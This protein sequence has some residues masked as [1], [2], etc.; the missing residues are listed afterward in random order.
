MN[1]A[2]NEFGRIQHTEILKINTGER[3]QCRSIGKAQRGHGAAKIDWE[4]KPLEIDSHADTHCFGSNF[5]PIYFTQHE[6][7][8][9]P[10]LPEYSEQVNIQI[11][12]GATAYTAENG[13]V[14]VLI[15]GQGLWFGDKMERSLINPYQCRAYGVDL[16]DDPVDPNGREMGIDCE[17]TFIPLSMVGSTCGTI[18][19]CP[20]DEELENCTKVYLSDEEDWDPSKENIFPDKSNKRLNAALAGRS[21]CDITLNGR[22]TKTVIRDD[23]FVNEFDRAMIDTN[24]SLSQGAMAERLINNVNVTINSRGAASTITRERHHGKDPELIA[25]K[26]G[27]GLEKAKQTLKATTQ[28]AVRS[29]V[30]P[31]TRRYRTDLMSQ[32]LRRLNCRFYTDTLFSKHK[33]IEGNTCGQLF[34]DGEGFVILYPMDSKAKAGQKLTELS[35]DVGI[36]NELYMDNAPE[37]VGK[38]SEMMKE[39]RRMKI[40]HH[41][42]EPYSPW[43]NAA[44]NIIGIIKSKHHQRMIRR[45]VPFD[46]WDYG[47]VWEAQIYSRTANKDGKVGL[48]RLTGDSIDISDWIDFEFYDIVWY[49][50]SQSADEKPKIGRWLGVSHNVGS[51]LCYFV[52]TEK[53]NVIS[54]T[55]VQHFTS[56]DVSKP[57]TQQAMRDY[58][59]N[60]HMHIK[61]RGHVYT[62]ETIFYGDDEENNTNQI[63]QEESYYPLPETPELDDVLNFETPEAAADS[64][65]QYIGVEVQMGPDDGKGNKLMAKVTKRLRDN[66][67]KTVTT[68]RAQ[69]PLH[70]SSIYEVEY[71][72]GTTEQL[73][74]NIIAENMMSQIDSEGNQFLLLNEIQDHRKDGR[75]VSRANGFI[76]SSGGNR[77]PKKTTAGWQLL[78]EWKDGSMDWVALKDLKEANPLELAEYAVAN[79]ID[80][81]PAFNWWVRDAIKRRDRIISKVKAK[82]WRTTHKFGIRIPKTVEE[83]YQIDRET[84]TDY[85]TKAIAKEMKNVRI[86]FERIPNVSPEQMKSGK[87]KPGHKFC[88]THM[89]FDIKMDGQFTRKAR[90]VADGHKT[91]APSSITYSSVV[92]RDSVRLAFTIAALNDLEVMACDIG[93]AYLNAPCRE[94]LWTTAGPE[95]GS[96]AGSVMTI[97]RALYG[98]KSSGAAWRAKFA[99][100]LRSMG[101]K[102]TEADP[103]VWMKKDFKETGEPYYKYIL[104]LAVFFRKSPLLAGSI[105]SS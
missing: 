72:D 48:E 99:D 76:L 103:D 79:N 101:Y 64:Y 98:L 7:T 81:E 18:T 65:D 88:D 9:S 52:L 3:R 39:I 53:G 30:L 13:E 82:Y 61:S 21:I 26:W 70:D 97:S 87:V 85:W 4:P 105:Y 59:T 14:F 2:W 25:R 71:P 90:L 51:A 45:N 63:D 77:H 16:C 29:A 62:G 35:H 66:D 74:A 33:S 80:D 23:M 102:P 50:D 28:L 24:P 32:R 40:R 92:S 49:W 8:V 84:G 27:I 36:P 20:T 41:T 10:F 37:Q 54:R 47:M 73:T 43:Q 69:N 42:T 83:A 5:R 1:D 75:A 46:L 104:G 56:D 34:T 89:I 6:C 22:S 86:A 38:N 44:E 55:S 100:T 94:K 58:H 95:F 11:C 31:L 78:V 60:M 57:E 17:E 67:G 12:T 91:D 68:A 19:R 15:F 93:N 96:E